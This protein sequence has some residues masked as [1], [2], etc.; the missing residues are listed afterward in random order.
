MH[1]RREARG[2]AGRAPVAHGVNLPREADLLRELSHEFHN[3]AVF[4]AVGQR[5]Q[6]VCNSPPSGYQ[7]NVDLANEGWTILDS[8]YSRC[9]CR[10]EKKL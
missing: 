2:V 4:F 1:A 10:L 3:R 9:C 7:Q 5:E 8:A 6:R